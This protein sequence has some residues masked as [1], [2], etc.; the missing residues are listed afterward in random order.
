MWFEFRSFLEHN[1][2]LLLRDEKLIKQLATRF[3]KPFDGKHRLESKLQ[4]RAAGRPSPDRADS[5]IL[6]FSHYKSKLNEEQGPVPFTSIIEPVKP[7]EVFTL[8]KWAKNNNS[9]DLNTFKRNI[10]QSDKTHLMQE[11]GRIN[12]EIREQ[13]KLAA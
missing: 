8:K 9:D 1:E 7:V 10:Y 12:S 13:Q 3:H 5:V 11:I 6:C 2:I 4:A